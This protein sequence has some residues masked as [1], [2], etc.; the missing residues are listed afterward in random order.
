MLILIEKYK[1][2]LPSIRK[3]FFKIWAFK[4]ELVGKC[5]IND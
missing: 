3:N 5:L 2:G 4:E 1:M